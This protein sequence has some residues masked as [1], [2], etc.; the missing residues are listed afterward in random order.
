[1]P[2][3]LKP[4][5]SPNPN[6]ANALPDKVAEIDKLTDEL[7]AENESLKD[8]L[9]AI[10]DHLGMDLHEFGRFKQDGFHYSA[11]TEVGKHLDS[12]TQKLEKV[13]GYE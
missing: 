4:I 2:S 7:I 8:E 13:L 10:R 1:M 3:P 9:E 5:P 6:A 12:I 11:Q